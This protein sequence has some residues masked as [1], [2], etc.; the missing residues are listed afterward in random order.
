MHWYW[1]RFHSFNI[2]ILDY[3]GK[4]QNSFSSDTKSGK[5]NTLFD[6][7]FRQMAPNSNRI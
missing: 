1:Q 7:N 2:Y 6:K 3:E 5:F 4:T